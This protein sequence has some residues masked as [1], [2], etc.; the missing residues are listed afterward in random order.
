MANI[1]EFQRLRVAHDLISAELRISWV[2]N[3]TGVGLRTLRLWWKEIHGKNPS[4]GKLPESVLHFIRNQPSASRLSAVALFHRKLQG[5]T[6]DA[7]SLLSTW[8]SFQA[9]CGPI[10]INAYYLAVRDVET[11]MVGLLECSGCEASYLH[12]P[13]NTNTNRC[14]FCDAHVAY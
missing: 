14:P 2:R 5:R 7:D 9:I 6:L 12:D 13:T 3:L 4:P 10:D 8:L 11:G 1:S